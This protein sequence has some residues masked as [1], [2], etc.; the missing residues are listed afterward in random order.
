MVYRLN[1][2]EA[3]LP[4]TVVDRSKIEIIGFTPFVLRIIWIISNLASTQS[5]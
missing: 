1:P 5:I 4:R 2:V 3:H